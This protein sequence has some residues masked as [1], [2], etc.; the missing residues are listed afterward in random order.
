MM[1]TVGGFE[2]NSFLARK[3]EFA[4]NVCHQFRR[5]PI[6]I[7]AHQFVSPA[8]NHRGSHW[9]FEII[10]Y[11]NGEIKPPRLALK[12]NVDIVKEMSSISKSDGV[13]TI[14]VLTTCLIV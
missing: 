5:R 3:F 8:Q 7:N 1:S 12:G 6:Q 13:S 4:P 11:F 10:V 2:I 9:S 14:F